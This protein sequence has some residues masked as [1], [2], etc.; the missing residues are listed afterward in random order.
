MTDT[1]PVATEISRLI[2]T[3]TQERDLVVA[4]AMRFPELTSAELSQALQ[5]ATA[6]AERRASTRH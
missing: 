6:E 3:G 5:V 4:I 1:S 2:A